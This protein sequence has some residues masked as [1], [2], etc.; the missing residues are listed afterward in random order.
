V[1]AGSDARRRTQAA[2]GDDHVARIGQRSIA[3]GSTLSPT[4]RPAA[5]GWAGCST[6]EGAATPARQEI[7]S[8]GARPDGIGSVEDDESRVAAGR[9]RSIAAGGLEAAVFRGIVVVC[10]VLLVIVTGRLMEPA[11]RGLYALA[12]LTAGLC[13]L[14]FGAVWIATAIEVNRRR[15]TLGELFGGSIV[16][17]VAGGSATALVAFAFAPLLGDRW[18]LVALPAAVTP[19]MLLGRYQEGLYTSVGHIRAV[20]LISVARAV[21]P[22]VFITP[23]LLAGASP[24]TAIAIWVLWW[25][26][27]PAIVYFPARSVFGRPRL[28]RDRGFYGRVVRFGSKIAG[29]NAVTML[30]ERVGLVALAL[31]STDADVGIY[32]VA[33]AGTQALLLVTESLALTAFQRIGGGSR[34]ESTALTLRA[35]RHSILIAAVGCVV[36]VPVAFF[37]VTWTVGPEYVDVPLLFVLLTPATVCGAAFLPLYVFFEVQIAT[38]AARLRVAGSALLANVVFCLAL[39]PMWGRW[40]AAAGTSLAFMLAGVVAF[41]VFRAESGARLR[42]LRPGR[43][44]LRDYVDLARSFGHRRSV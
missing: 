30:N 16:V 6:T 4:T 15:A 23:P 37:A 22:L 9:P 11:G 24:R 21:L 7:Q 28:P 31:F 3:I 29:L 18:W 33:I 27:L 41:S 25:V 2:L 38:P 40:G 43:Q 8:S 1:P 44:E 10:L 32:S 39:A 13:G 35:V 14:P 12:A 17:A 26:A 42:Q 34:E 19:F 36:L 5:G 20:N